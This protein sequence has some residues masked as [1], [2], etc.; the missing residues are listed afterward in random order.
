[1]DIIQNI[2][3]ECI[4][5]QIENFD[6]LSEEEL[7]GKLNSIFDSI[8]DLVDQVSDLIKK[9]LDKNSTSMLLEHQNFRK[10]FEKDHQLLWDKGLNLLETFI[11]ISQEAGEEFNKN[12][13]TEAAKTDDY[14]FDVL[15]RLHS[16]AIQ[17]AYEVLALLKSGFADGAHARWRTIHEITVVGLFICNYGQVVAERYLLHEIIESY[18]A[19]NQYNKYCKNLGQL[20]YSEDEVNN[21]KIAHDKLVT[22]Y[23]I[24]FCSQYGWAANITKNKNTKFFHIE[25][26]SGMEHLRPYYKMAS[27]NVHANPKGIKFKLGL[28]LEVEE[29]LLAGPSNYGLADPAHGAAISILQI[30]SA[31]L[32]HKTNFDNLVILKIL[33]KY[34]EEIGSAFLKVNN[35]MKSEM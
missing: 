23:G 35:F 17:V 24:E 16:R 14:V 4:R 34:E 6:N 3:K 12:Y 33:S 19:M 21:M 29:I 26:K 30:T 27:H 8:P 20:P 32:T 18:K 10:N 13:R 15:T 31:L 22:R 28:S 5:D 25:K 9:T 7:M 11:V 2:F 1:M